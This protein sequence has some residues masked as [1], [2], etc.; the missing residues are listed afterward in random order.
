MSNHEFLAG[1]LFQSFKDDKL[2]QFVK[3]HAVELRGI[4][5]EQIIAMAKLFCV[6]DTAFVTEICPVVMGLP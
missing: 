4:N 6:A 2:D 1:E 3:D 5:V